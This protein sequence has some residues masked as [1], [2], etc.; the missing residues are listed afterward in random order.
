MQLWYEG[1]GKLSDNIA[2]PRKF[3][4]WNTII[5]EGD[6]E[7]HANDALFTVEL[8]SDG[9]Q[10]I[11]QPLTLTAIDSRG[12]VLA[13]RVLIRL[14]TNGSGNTT[15]ALWVR[16]VGCAGRVNFQA[17]FGTAKRSVMLDFACGE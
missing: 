4:L 12:K 10:N 11:T 3:A 15:S 8:H 9:E 2:P 13:R 6:A 1:T 16:D 7:E 14:L 17:Q 5:G